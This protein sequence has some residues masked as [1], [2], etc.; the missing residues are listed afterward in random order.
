MERVADEAGVESTR[1]SF[2]AALR[3][4]CDAWLWCALAS[5][6]AARDRN[7]PAFRL[8]YLAMG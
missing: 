1:I 6:T 7:D 2:V 4:I 5:A 8:S 3:F